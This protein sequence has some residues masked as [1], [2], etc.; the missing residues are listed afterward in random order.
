[1]NEHAER[2]EFAT[3]RAVQDDFSF[4]YSRPEFAWSRRLLI[5]TIEK[6]TGQRTLERMYR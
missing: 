6:L 2:F 3:A 4:S 5:R 1:M